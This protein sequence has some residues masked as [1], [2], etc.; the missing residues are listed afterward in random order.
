MPKSRKTSA[1]DDPH[2]C[3]EDG[4]GLRAPIGMTMP[5]SGFKGFLQAVELSGFSTWVRESS[6]LW[7][8]PGVLFLHTLGLA[9]VVGMSVAISLRVLGVGSAA[10]IKPMEKFFPVM[11]AGFWINTFSGTIL[12]AIDATNKLSS[13]VFYIKMSCIVL[14]VIAVQLTRN[15][16]FRDPDTE[17][18]GVTTSARILAAVSIA[19]WLGAIV[20]GRLMAYLSAPHIP[21]AST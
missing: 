10:P 16:V 1:D 11:W 17:T 3:R 2:S 9:F 6:S 21:G 5:A 8:Y 4:R 20:A 7:A 15:R 14:A 13:P 18:K 12:L 19:L